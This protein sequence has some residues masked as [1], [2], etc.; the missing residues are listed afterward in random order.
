MNFMVVVVAL[1]HGVS[2]KEDVTKAKRNC[3]R[4]RIRYFK[5]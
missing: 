3:H 2:T 1:P 4:E 5:S